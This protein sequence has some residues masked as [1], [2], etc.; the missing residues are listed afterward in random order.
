MGGSLQ[1]AQVTAIAAP[2]VVAA[3]CIYAYKRQIGGDYL[4]LWVVTHVGLGIVF[5]LTA[6]IPNSADLADPPAALIIAY[7]IYGGAG[8]TVPMAILCLTYPRVRMRHGIVVG[9][10]V[11]SAIV[12]AQVL[13]DAR[14]VSLVT[15]A[16]VTA[17]FAVSAGLLLVRDR[18]APYLFASGVLLLRAGNS[19][20]Y[21]MTVWRSGVPVVTTDTYVVSVFLNFLAGASL[22]VIA[23]DEAWHRL[24]SALAESHRV[25][26]LSEA[27][28]DIAP[29]S[30]LVKDRDLTIVNANQYAVDLAARLRPNDG[31]LIGKRLIELSPGA[32]AATGEAMDRAL[33]ADP[34]AGPL[35]YEGVYGHN[36]DDQVVMLVRKAALVD[37]SGEAYGTITVSLDISEMKRSEQKLRELFERAEQANKDK[38]DFLANM[39]H[40]LRT[41]LNGI[42][43]FAE[44]LA[45]GFHGGLTDR[46]KDYVDNILISSRLMLDLVSDV[47]DLSSLE[48]QRLELRREPVDLAEIAATVTTGAEAKAAERQV[49]LQVEVPSLVVNV[50][51]QAVTRAL[52][53]LVDN[54]IVFNRPGGEVRLQA[55]RAG[56][57]TTMSVEDTGIGMTAEQIAASDVP[58][59]RGNPMTARNGGGSGLGLVIARRIIEA[60]GGTLT[61]R[62]ERERGTKVTVNL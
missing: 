34:T 31:R 9:T 22:L 23:V 4:A 62:S 14:V 35:E 19:L 49:M 10:F 32:N 58:F 29:V 18:S 33:L 30:I 26:A 45:T 27:V 15:P 1:L 28:L 2:L 61:I 13:T 12:L 20:A 44:M 57:R 55:S 36:G 51:R 47:L 5:A 16:M 8:I 54:A 52:G 60:H 41:P 6:F 42:N 48:Q 56:D 40:E 38:T 11:T 37:E 25:N 3:L 43:G 59:L 17:G 46:Q 21:A 53:N 24:R 39:S 50:D 7:G